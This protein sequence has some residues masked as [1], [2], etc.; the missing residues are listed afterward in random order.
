MEIAEQT[1]IFSLGTESRL[2]EKELGI[3]TS[4]SPLKKMN[5][6][7]ILSEAKGLDKYTHTIL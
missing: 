5:L 6:C 2:K 7:Y 1:V 4:C 3:Q